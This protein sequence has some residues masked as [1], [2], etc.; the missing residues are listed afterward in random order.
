MIDAI[1]LQTSRRVLAD[2]GY[3]VEPSGAVLR[4]DGVEAGVFLRVVRATRIQVRTKCN[5][6]LLWSGSPR[7]I[8]SFVERYWF[9]ERLDSAAR[10][11]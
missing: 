7:D 4:P 6:A 8:G 9:A 2:Y 3:Q 5:S 11:E 10:Q 1:T